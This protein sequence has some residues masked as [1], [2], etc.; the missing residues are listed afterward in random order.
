MNKNN[1]ICYV[2]LGLATISCQQSKKIKTITKGEN[3]YYVVGD[4]AYFIKNNSIVS[5]TNI[6]GNYTVD[7]DANDINRIKSIQFANEKNILYKK[8]KFNQN[9]LEK[10]VLTDNN[11]G[12]MISL[13]KDKEK[14][15]YAI[16]YLIEDYDIW[17]KHYFFTVNEK[18]DTTDYM[19]YRENKEGFQIFTD[20][21]NLSLTN[22]AIDAIELYYLDS[23]LNQV[24]YQVSEEASPLYMPGINNVAPKKVNNTHQ[25][26]TKSSSILGYSWTSFKN[27]EFSYYLY[28]MNGNLMRR[29]GL[30]NEEFMQDKMAKSGLAVDQSDILSAIIK[31]NAYELVN[32]KLVRNSA[33]FK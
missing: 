9:K 13:T 27:G 8:I 30:F 28:R 7:F 2:I 1:F 23:S 19:Y 33:E 32:G 11:S 24:Y 17:K 26:N 16:S 10:Y 14:S 5:L 20:R 29:V 18:L 3:E 25:I 4:I 22:S 21:S 31:S 15:K 12:E 6:K